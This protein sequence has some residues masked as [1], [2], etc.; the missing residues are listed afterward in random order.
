MQVERYT[1]LEILE[2]MLGE[3]NDDLRDSAAEILAEKLDYDSDFI[4]DAISAYNQ[5]DK[6]MIPISSTQ[7]SKA[8]FSI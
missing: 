1:G 3:K 8:D 7:D 6:E 2:T 4:R 5:T